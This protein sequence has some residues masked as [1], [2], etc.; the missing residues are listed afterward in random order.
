MYQWWGS[1]AFDISWK[2]LQVGDRVRVSGSNEAGQ[3][4]EISEIGDYMVQFDNGFI[5]GYDEDML[6]K[7][8]ASS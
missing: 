8:D 7:A 1:H 5:C 4:I 2:E 6:S 3:L